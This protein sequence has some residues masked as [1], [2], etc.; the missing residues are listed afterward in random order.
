LKVFLFAIVGRRGH[1][2]VVVGH[3]RQRLTQPISVGLSILAR[4]AHLVRFI[5]DDQVPMAA[6]Q[7]FFCIVDA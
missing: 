2:Q 1:Q 7:G 4:S 6:Q 5:D 3:L